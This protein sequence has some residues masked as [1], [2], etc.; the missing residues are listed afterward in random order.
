MID[1]R[2]IRTHAGVPQQCLGWM[3]RR[4]AAPGAMREREREREEGAREEEEKRVNR[5]K[6]R[7]SAGGEEGRGRGTEAHRD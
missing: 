4:G 7:S 1:G 2:C 3:N 5:A 6:A